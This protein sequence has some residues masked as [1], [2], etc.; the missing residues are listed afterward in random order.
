[1]YQNYRSKEEMEAIPF[2]SNTL[3]FMF[4]QLFYGQEIKDTPGPGYYAGS[5]N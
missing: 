5:S 4:K 3:R 1:M 2:G